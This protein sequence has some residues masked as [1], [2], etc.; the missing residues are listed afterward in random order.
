MFKKYLIIASK[1]DAAGV[2]ITTHLSQ[3]RKNPVL[4][5]I[6]KDNSSFDFYLVE[7][8]ILHEENLDL[9][10]INKY[11]FVI[12]ASKHSSGSREKTLS[13]HSPGNWRIARGGGKSE[14]ISPSSALFQKIM[15]E[16]LNKQAEDSGLTENNNEHQDKYKV[17]LECTHHGPLINKP[18][19]FIEIGSTETEWKDRAAAFVL[20]KTIKKTIDEFQENPYREVGIGL[21]GPHYCPNFNKIQRDSNVAISHIIP[22]YMIPITEDMINE[23]WKKTIEEVDFVV[24]DWKG[25]GKSAQR[26]ELI[27]ILDK[28]HIQWKKTS[29]ISK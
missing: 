7:G 14:K 28:N 27:D 17:T 9:E 24:L 20:A 21:G 6:S 18:C 22:G 13:V 10:K 1:Q 19:L 4:S 15:F 8:D 5:G 3:F 26:Q 29:D 2:N 12:F 16:N 11:D 23:A 25:L